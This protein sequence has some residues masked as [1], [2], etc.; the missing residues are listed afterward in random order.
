MFIHMNDLSLNSPLTY[1]GSKKRFTKKIARYFPKLDS[2]LTYCE[3]FAGSLSMFLELLPNVAILNDKCS[4][5]YS[6]WKAIQLY[7]DDFQNEIDHML[8]GDDWYNEYLR[9]IQSHDNGSNILSEKEI[10]ISKAIILYMQTA[11]NMSS[12]FNSKQKKMSF[13]IPCIPIQNDFKIYN[14]ILKDGKRKV[15]IYNRDFREVIER[16]GKWSITDRNKYILYLDPPYF[17]EGKN[18]ENSF[19]ASDHMDLHDLLKK[20]DHQWILSYDNTE[21][22]RELYDGYYM[23]TLDIFYT[24]SNS[25]K[26][27]KLDSELIISNYELK[28]NNQTNI[29]EYF[30]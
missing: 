20:I 23:D 10:M 27:R 16:I 1:F 29:N 6:F 14:S 17:E 4:Y 13:R 30:M 8:F 26:K 2:I 18:Y 7:Y 22:V 9:K 15:T 24:A 12:I 25:Q 28:I 21:K 5:I 11:T 19:T 3:I